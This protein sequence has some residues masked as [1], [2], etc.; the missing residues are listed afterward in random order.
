MDMIKIREMVERYPEAHKL[1]CP[2][3]HY[4]ARLLSV[5]PNE[6]GQAADDLKSKITFCQLGLFGYGR[7]GVSAYKI[8]GRK[9]DVSQAV[10]DRVRAA[11]SQENSI[12]CRQLWEIA[13]TE[14][15]FRVEIGECANTLG[16]KIVGCQLRAF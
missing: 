4:I 11:A 7:K 13:D 10:I 1:P 6:V 5:D 15:V 12:S 9:V 14:G 8:L 16:L 3:A 2:V